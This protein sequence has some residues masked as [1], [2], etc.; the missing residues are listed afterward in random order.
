VK[1]LID[2]HAAI[3]A[4]S[5]PARLKPG[6]AEMLADPANE[7]W[8]SLA[9][10]WELSV[11]HALG[12]LAFEPRDLH[13]ACLTTGFLLLPIALDHALGVAELPHHHRDPFDRMIIAQAKLEGLV[14]VTHDDAFRPYGVPIL[15]T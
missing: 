13:H 7:I 4:T 14:I 9:T 10:T 12:R 2:S 8:F 11:K 5:H 3:W 15:W 6:V 1:L